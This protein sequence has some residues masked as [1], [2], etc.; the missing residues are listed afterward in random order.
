MNDS[1]MPEREA[2]E[3]YPFANAAVRAYFA[4]RGRLPTPE[5]E[6]VLDECLR[7]DSRFNLLL[8]RYADVRIADAEAARCF[9]GFIKRRRPQN[10]YITLR[11]LSL[12]EL[13]KPC[14][15][16]P[17]PGD[18]LLYID[19]LP[20]DRRLQKQVNRHAFF[21]LHTLLALAAGLTVDLDAFPPACG[22]VGFDELLSMRFLA[23]DER[24]VGR[25]R[26]QLAKASP[27]AQA[28]M[29]VVGVFNS[30]G[31]LTLLRAQEPV[32]DV[33]SSLLRETSERLYN[34]EIC[35]AEEFRAGMLDVADALL[36]AVSGL[37]NHLVVVARERTDRSALLAH[38]LG[39]FAAERALSVT[40]SG[41]VPQQGEKRLPPFEKSGNLLYAVPIGRSTGEAYLHLLAQTL[42]RLQADIRSGIVVRA[43][44]CAGTAEEMLAGLCGERYRFLPAP[45]PAVCAEGDLLLETRMPI[46]APLLGRCEAYGED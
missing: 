26:A 29:T 16:I 41:C 3:A 2:E 15:Q 19:D 31:T 38:R 42:P 10:G 14:A 1:F 30:L 32:V 7:A 25:L 22:R 34:A 37:R 39:V 20:F 4:D 35:G 11:D 44:R 40:V 5:E 21:G 23:A 18:L 6:A 36:T 17:R 43:L 24:A 9:E 28:Q 12:L 27:Y 33:A 45:T 46:Q 13:E 8:T